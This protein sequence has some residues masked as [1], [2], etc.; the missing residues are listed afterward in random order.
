M[1]FVAL[2]AAMVSTR[3]LFFLSVHRAFVIDNTRSI[4]ALVPGMAKEN[5]KMICMYVCMLLNEMPS[6]CTNSNT[7]E[8]HSTVLMKFVFHSLILFL[9]IYLCL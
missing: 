2:T 4:D 8:H 1:C 3:K 7:S 6:L 5:S 9:L